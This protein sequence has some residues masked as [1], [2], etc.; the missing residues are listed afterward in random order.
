MEDIFSKDN[1]RVKLW[2]SLLANKGRKK[3]GKFLL[4]SIRGIEE[5][6]IKG[7]EPE[8][9]I[10]REG[11]VIPEAFRRIETIVFLETGPFNSLCDTENSQGFIGIY[12][13]QPLNM[14]LLDKCQHLF[15]VDGIQ[16]PGNLGTLI[17]SGGAFNIDGLLL[18]EGTVDP[19]NSKVL[20]STMGGIFTF[21]IFEVTLETIAVLKEKGFEI[22]ASTFNG[23]PLEE[24]QPAKPF[25]LGIGNE[26]KGLTKE[27]IA[28]ADREVTIPMV[29][30]ESLNA[31]VAGSIFMYKNYNPIN[32]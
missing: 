4:E 23:L 24:W 28:L 29:G 16:D 10:V 32:L 7:F 5:G 9:L 11:M 12:P 21:P 18:G 2:R 25:V 8:V 15:Y 31:G 30:L 17:R 13:I 20:R 19:Y 27:F 22:V 3:E 26:N 6:L 14:R 1:E